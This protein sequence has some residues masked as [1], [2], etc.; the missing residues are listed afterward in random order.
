MAL[1]FEDQYPIV[2]NIS[3][4]YRSNRIA[5]IR[6]WLEERDLFFQDSWSFDNVDDQFVIRF[7]QSHEYLTEFKLRFG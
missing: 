2:V 3:Q 6:I 4:I 7:T 5:D 1:I